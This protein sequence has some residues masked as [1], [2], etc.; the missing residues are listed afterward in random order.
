MRKW[1]YQELRINHGEL[2]A[3]CNELG[4]QGW[5]L[6]GEIQFIRGGYSYPEH[7]GRYIFKRPGDVIE[8]F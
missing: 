5:E 6:C 2:I 8:R 1:A 7:A 3:K 4:A